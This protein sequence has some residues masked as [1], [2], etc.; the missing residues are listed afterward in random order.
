MG[1]HTPIR[2]LGLYNAE[3]H[4]F[5]GSY[6]SKVALFGLYQFLHQRWQFGDIFLILECSRGVGGYGQDI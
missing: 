4:E 5:Q 6:P 2:Q 3:T 1:L